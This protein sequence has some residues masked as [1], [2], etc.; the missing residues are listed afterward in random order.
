MHTYM[1]EKQNNTAIIVTTCVATLLSVVGLAIAVNR[2]NRRNI[3]TLTA[4]DVTDVLH[5][6]N[7][8]LE[9]IQS[10]QSMV[11]DKSAI[12]HSNV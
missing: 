11:P 4:R 1:E 6:I 7:C 10:A 8:K 9:Q 2:R 12:I 5:D 3:V